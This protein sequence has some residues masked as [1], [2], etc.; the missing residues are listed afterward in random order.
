MTKEIKKLLGNNIRVVR[1][2]RKLSVKEVAEKSGLAR[3]TLANIESGL[4][5]ISINNLYRI[6]KALDIDILK[7]LPSSDFFFED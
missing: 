2:K 4:D 6:S 7:I 1:K 3:V 5:A